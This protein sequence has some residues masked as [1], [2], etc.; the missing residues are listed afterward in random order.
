MNNLSNTH[1]IRTNFLL[2]YPV[3]ISMLGQVMTG[4]A[5]AE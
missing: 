3:M 2:A 4:V 1:H 5:I